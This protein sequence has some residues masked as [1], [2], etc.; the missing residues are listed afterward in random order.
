MTASNGNSVAASSPVVASRYA[1][2][3]ISPFPSPDP[4]FPFPAPDPDFPFP[5]PNPDFPF[6]D[7]DPDFPFPDPNPDVPFL[8]GTRATT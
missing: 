8:A 6:P 3:H 2:P 1:R 5:D 7:P 4:D